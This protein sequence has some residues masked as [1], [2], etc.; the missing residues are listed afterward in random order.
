VS[1]EGAPL[2]A[3]E[4]GSAQPAPWYTTNSVVRPSGAAEK[5][6]D[7]V[8]VRAARRAASEAHDWLR[9]RS[10]S[11]E[12]LRTCGR[13]RIG[14]EVELR[15]HVDGAQ[16]RASWSGVLRCGDVWGCPSCAV[17]LKA[18]RAEQL[19]AVSDVLRRQGL[20]PVLVSLTVRHAWSHDLRQMR[21]GLASAWRRVQQSRYWRTSAL[22][23]GG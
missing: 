5:P 6:S 2:R 13:Q 23:S 11:S 17:R 21:Q 16:R 19:T 3:S 4:G 20:V 12:R 8:H 22:R 9:R 14:E 1:P 10:W 18:R 7:S 15:V